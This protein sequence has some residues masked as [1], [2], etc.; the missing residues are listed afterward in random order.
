MISFKNFCTK[1]IVKKIQLGIQER[2]IIYILI[3]LNMTFGFI[4]KLPTNVT[5]EKMYNVLEYTH[6]Y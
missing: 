4:E 5:I 1:Q 6:L 3:F 2:K